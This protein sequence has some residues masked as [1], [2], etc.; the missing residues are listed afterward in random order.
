M[1]NIPVLPAVGRMILFYLFLLISILFLFLKRFPP[2]EISIPE[3]FSKRTKFL[4]FIIIVG[5]FHLPFWILPIPTG[6][7]H[8]SHAGPAAYAL[9]KLSSYIDI[10][11]VRLAAWLIVLLLLL[12]L[13][14]VTFLLAQDISV[15]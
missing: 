4:P 8:Q 13:C 15:A 14:S 2:V 12:I 6:G 9:S 11:Y 3:W 5:L 7:D 10:R 1:W